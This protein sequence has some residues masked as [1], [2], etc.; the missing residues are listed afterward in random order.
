MNSPVLNGN[1]YFPRLEI[2]LKELNKRRSFFPP[3]E[4]DVEQ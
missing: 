4:Q 1:G 2:D 3:Q